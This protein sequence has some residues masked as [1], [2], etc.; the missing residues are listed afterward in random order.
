MRIIAGDLKGMRLSPPAGNK[1][2]PTTD[3]VKESIFNIIM[4]YL[5]DAVVVDLFAG[6]GNLG[7]EAI[8][9]G[10]A[11][12]YFGDN[13][14]DSIALVKKNIASCKVQNKSV[15]I[16]GDYPFVLSKISE[17]ADVIF[18]DPPYAVGAIEECLRVIS[19]SDVLSEEGIVVTEH[20][21]KEGLPERVGSLYKDKEK[22][23]G[24][25]GITVYGLDLEEDI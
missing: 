14:K 5:E 4:G 25:V 1:V 24:T 13:S 19:E 23:Y 22:R 9:R 21:S 16:F 10:A 17:K 12:C 6:T 8:S 2:R 7:L 18:L 20:D 15:T 11:K 3:K